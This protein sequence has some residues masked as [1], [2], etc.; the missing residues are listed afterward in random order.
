MARYRD[1]AG[2]G[3][4]LL[5]PGAYVADV[6]ESVATDMA[7]IMASVVLDN[8]AAGIGVF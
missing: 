2:S 7:R 5:A 6:A 8:L 4:L 1:E 3:V